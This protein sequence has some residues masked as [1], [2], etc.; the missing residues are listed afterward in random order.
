MTIVITSTLI[1]YL[2]RL[3]GMGNEVVVQIL[4]EHPQKDT[5]ARVIQMHQN[6]GCCNVGCIAGGRMET[7][8]GRQWCI[9][10][11]SVTGD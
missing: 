11:V 9:N 3:F 5:V 4:Q 10:V 1:R 8:V 6:C 2:I 7:D